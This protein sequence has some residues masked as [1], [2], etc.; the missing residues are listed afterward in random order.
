MQERRTSRMLEAALQRRSGESQ[1]ATSRSS[2][3]AT[4]KRLVV[5]TAPALAAMAKTALPPVQEAPVAPEEPLGDNVT[6]F[7]PRSLGRA[8]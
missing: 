6:R 3:D 2:A 5:G 1:V 4:V 8:A 7:R